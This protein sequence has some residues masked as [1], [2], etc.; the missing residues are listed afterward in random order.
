MCA[1]RLHVYIHVKNG[2]KTAG[3]DMHVYTNTQSCINI[4]MYMYIHTCTLGNTHIQMHTHMYSRTH[5]HTR[6]RTCTHTRTHTHAHTHAHTHTRMQS[7]HMCT[8]MFESTANQFPI[9]CPLLEKLTKQISSTHSRC[10]VYTDPSHKYC[11]PSHTYWLS[12]LAA[13]TL[14]TFWEL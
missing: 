12:V 7:T 11:L 6:T 1:W 4:Y 13:L 14:P 2:D 10:V 8:Q 5:T 3:A 9:L